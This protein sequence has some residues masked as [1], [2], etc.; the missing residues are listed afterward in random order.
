[1]EEIKTEPH[2]KSMPQS[3]HVF[4]CFYFGVCVDSLNKRSQE[5][6]E[7]K[8]TRYLLALDLNFVLINVIQIMKHSTGRIWN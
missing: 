5:E 1:M 8:L 4:V 6:P 2:W 3:E 7:K